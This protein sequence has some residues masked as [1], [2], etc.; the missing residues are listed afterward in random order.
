MCFETEDPEFDPWAQFW[1]QPATSMRLERGCDAQAQLVE[2]DTL[3]HIYG[4]IFPS[5]RK[6]R[7]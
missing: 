1:R 6:I 3:P 5:L 4:R 2:I 7:A